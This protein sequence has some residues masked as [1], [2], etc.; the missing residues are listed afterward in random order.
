MNNSFS[1]T[2]RFQLA[3][4]GLDTSTS[5]YMHINLPVSYN[6][7]ILPHLGIWTVVLVGNDDCRAH[8]LGG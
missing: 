2:S 5:K 1:S 8:A 6:I 7:D 4:N 3:K